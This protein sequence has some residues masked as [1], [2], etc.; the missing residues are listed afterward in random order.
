MFV[1]PVPYVAPAPSYLGEA[2]GA[3]VRPGIDTA[4]ATLVAGSLVATWRAPLG[5]AVYLT[6]MTVSADT[7][8]AAYLYVG[9]PERVNLVS[10]TASGNFDENDPSQ[11]IYVPEGTPVTVVWQTAIG[12]ALVRVEYVPLG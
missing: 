2:G 1:E 8:C 4:A 10:G 7:A 5:G 11:P 3:D 6:R 9:T 12:A